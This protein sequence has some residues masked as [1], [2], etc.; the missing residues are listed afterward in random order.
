VPLTIIVI[1]QMSAFIYGMYT[2]AQGR[3]VWMVF[4]VDRFDLV[5]SYEVDESYRRIAEPEYQKLSLTGPKV[6]AARKP[7]DLEA[8][9]TLIFESMGGIDLPV[10]PDLYVSYEEELERVRSKAQP[11]SNLEKYNQKELVQETLADWP[12]ANAY[13]PMM[14]KVK[15]MTVLINRDSGGIVAMVPLNP[16]D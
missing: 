2:V 8:Q 6:V 11:L 1:L 5:Q 13:L 9:N 7:V 3:P 14:A 16:W 4:N 15:S 10:R 12:E